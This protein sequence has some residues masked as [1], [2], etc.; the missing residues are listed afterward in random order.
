MTGED[1]RLQILRA[2][3]LFQRGRGTTNKEIALAADVSEAMVLRHFATK[4]Q[5]YSAILDHGL[6][7]RDDG[8]FAH[9]S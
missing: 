2:M 4:E 3:R 6:P 9:R 8:S 5:L 1:R 7:A